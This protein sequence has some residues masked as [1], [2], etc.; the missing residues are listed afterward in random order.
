MA[1]LYIYSPDSHFQAVVNRYMSVGLPIAPVT[2]VAQLGNVGNFSIN[3][4]QHIRHLPV[5]FSLLRSITLLDK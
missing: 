5:D 3:N 2:S 1:A 4:S